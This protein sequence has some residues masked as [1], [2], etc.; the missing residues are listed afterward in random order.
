[1]ICLESVPEAAGVKSGVG[2]RGTLHFREFYLY[3]TAVRTL[4]QTV[5]DALIFVPA[6]CT[7]LPPPSPPP[8]SPVKYRYKCLH[9]PSFCIYIPIVLSPHFTDFLLLFFRLD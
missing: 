1:M 4:L 3:S 2:E 9:P 7:P 6:N 8:P 5:Y